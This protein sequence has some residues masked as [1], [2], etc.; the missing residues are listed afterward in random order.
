MRFRFRGRVCH[1]R[2]C[3]RIA[4][5]EKA[6]RRGLAPCPTAAAYVSLAELLLARGVRKSEFESTQAK[7]QQ[8]DPA[9]GGT[10]MTRGEWFVAQGRAAEAVAAFEQALHLDPVNFSRRARERINWVRNNL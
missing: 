4:P 9:Y 6:L 1:Y 8:L 2:R 3:D 5:A 7:A 10:Y